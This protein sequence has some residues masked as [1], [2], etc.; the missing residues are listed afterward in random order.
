MTIPRIL[1]LT[2]PFLLSACVQQ[3]LMGTMAADNR[4][5]TLYDYELLSASNEPMTFEALASKLVDADV[6]M[7]GEW[8]AH[9]AVHLFQARLLSELTSTNSSLALSMEHFT[10]A[11]QAVLDRYLADEIGE[12]TLINNTAAWDNYK[13]DYRPLVEIARHN[14]LDVIAANAPRDIVKCI[15]RNGPEYL[16]RLPK[17]KQNL[18]AAKIDVSDSPYRQKFLEGMQGMELT[19]KRI[20]KMFGAQMAWDATMAESMAH[21]LQQNPG[22]KVLHVAGRFHIIGGLGTGAELKKLMP[23]LNIVY[24]SSETKDDPIEGHDDIRLRVQALPPL[25]VNKTERAEVMKLHTRSKVEC[26]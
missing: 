25:W 13:S 15:G 9:P 21:Y 22:G 14:K 19:E 4:V 5:S 3:P 2:F 1:L 11:D 17:E 23:N 16:N 24:I 20:S 12:S 18:V 6:V 8:H 26:D 10:R 7:V